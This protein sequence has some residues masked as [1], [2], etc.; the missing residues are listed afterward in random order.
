VLVGTDNT[1]TKTTECKWE[2]KT[3]LTKKNTDLQNLRHIAYNQ[4]TEF[5]YL[6]VLNNAHI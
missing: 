4:K 3:Q 5:E 6:K 2:H 1:W